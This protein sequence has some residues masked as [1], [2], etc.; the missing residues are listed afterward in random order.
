MENNQRP[1]QCERIEQY[2]N[3]HGRITQLQA[4]NFLGIMRLASRIS[5]MRK[6]GAQ[7]GDRTIAVRN[8]YG[9]VCHIKEYFLLDAPAPAQSVFAQIADDDNIN[10]MFAQMFK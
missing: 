9:E 7:I 2:L 5:E 6:R 10:P 1:T 4:L 8:R 3:E